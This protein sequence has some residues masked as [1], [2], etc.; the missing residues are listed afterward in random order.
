MI[1]TDLLAEGQCSAP[2]LLGREEDQNRRC[3]CRCGGTWHGALAGA[4]LPEPG[5]RHWYEANCGWSQTWL[6]AYVPVVPWSVPTE[7]RLYRKA[8]AEG[9]AFCVVFKHGA[10]YELK[11]DYET[12]HSGSRLSEPATEAWERFVVELVRSRRARQAV[13]GW[14]LLS[15]TGVPTRIEAQVA[16]TIAQELR[17]ENLDGC[18]R[19]TAALMGVLV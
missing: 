17:S 1:A 3:T 2:C 11:V 19:C 7:N 6:D 5:D 15:L 9:R 18:E 13:L 14:Y 4:E 12:E 16:G 10:G 8:Q